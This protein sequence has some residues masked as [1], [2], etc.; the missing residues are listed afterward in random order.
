MAGGVA[1]PALGK[2]ISHLIGD[3]ETIRDVIQAKEKEFQKNK[4]KP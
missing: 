1:L 3:K 2:G 4:H